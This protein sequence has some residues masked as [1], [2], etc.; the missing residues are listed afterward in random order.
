MEGR[1]DDQGKARW[2]L[3]PWEDLE[4]IVDVFSFGAKKYEPNNWKKVPDPHNRY[5]AAVMRHLTA[6]R[7]GEEIDPETGIPHLAHA[8]C[9]LLFLQ[10]FD[11][12]KSAE[13][14]LPKVETVPFQQEER[15]VADGSGSRDKKTHRSRRK[16]S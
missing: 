2:D 14:I 9:S 11:R 10:W 15:T 13:T 12:H 6:W 1:K 4:R 7:K 3:V 16:I 8:G 5:F